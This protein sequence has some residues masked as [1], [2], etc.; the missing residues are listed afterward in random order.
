MSAMRHSVPG[1]ACFLAVACYQSHT[2]GADASI[3]PTDAGVDGN[4]ARDGSVVGD[5][6]ASGWECSR[7]AGFRRCG[8]ACPTECTASDGRCLDSLGV[9][10]PR[11]FPSD[12]DGCNLRPELG[13][14]PFTGRPCAIYGGTGSSGDPLR[15]V[16]MPPEFCLEAPGAG[17][18]V[19]CIWSD[20]T[21]VLSA[22]PPGT[23]PPSD[24]R[25]PFCGGSCGEDPVCPIGGAGDP[26]SCVGV[27]AHRPHGVCVYRGVFCSNDPERDPLFGTARL[28]EACSAE[29]GD[30]CA[31]L[32]LRPQVFPVD[33]EVGFPM[34]RSSCTAYRE[35]F[36]GGTSCVGADWSELP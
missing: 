6:D 25:N 24:P 23:C 28:L 20:G 8:E 12:D 21:P 26:G 3:G 1:I 9:C 4:I 7:I 22:P 36:P 10:R 34:L 2:G 17:L 19:R 14:Y 18:D 11:P 32:V 13:Y 33:Y 16:G 31:C 35:L 27:S 29:L 15:G 30:D 5:A